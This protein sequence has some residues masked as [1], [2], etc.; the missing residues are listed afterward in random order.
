MHIVL[1]F[2]A[3]HHFIYLS[4]DN[5]VTDAPNGLLARFFSVFTP[6][7]KQR[8]APGV[9]KMV[10]TATAPD[11]PRTP[12]SNM[13]PPRVFVGQDVL[14]SAKKQ[15]AELYYTPQTGLVYTSPNTIEMRDITTL[16]GRSSQRRRSLR[17]RKLRKETGLLGKLQYE[18]PR[19]PH[20]RD[21]ASDKDSS[22][23]PNETGEQL[24]DEV[25]VNITSHIP[26][27]HLPT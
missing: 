23:I 14:V 19:Q 3:D 12:L 2:I 24:K 20:I 5:T 21:E 15:K 18:S 25:D 10:D 27:L 26:L 4:S 16:S 7:K 6:A 17:R 8:I 11:E 1:V 13:G 9:E 22:D